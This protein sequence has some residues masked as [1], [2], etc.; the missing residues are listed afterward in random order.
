MSKMLA[1]Q[2]AMARARFNLGRWIA[3]L[4]EQEHGT[5]REGGSEGERERVEGMRTETMKLS[6]VLLLQP[7][8]PSMFS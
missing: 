5:G 7:A 3:N 4:A 1:T 2:Q 6:S 8:A